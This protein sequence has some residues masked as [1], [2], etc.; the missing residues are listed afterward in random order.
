MNKKQKAVLVLA[1]ILQML[2]LLFPHWN[3]YDLMGAYMGHYGMHYLFDYPLDGKVDI[4]MKIDY[5]LLIIHFF[6]IS[7]I[8]FCL[9]CLFRTTTPEIKSN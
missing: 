6:I 4:A 3:V 7:S 8:C 9:F 2:I 1:V 5:I